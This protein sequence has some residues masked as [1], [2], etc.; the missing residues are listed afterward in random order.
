MSKR[1]IS[2]LVAISFLLTGVIV[3]AQPK[4]IGVVPPAAFKARIDAIGIKLEK[5]ESILNK[6]ENNKLIAVEDSEDFGKT[7]YEYAETMKAAFEEAFKDS[8]DFAKSEGKTGSIE[9]LKSLEATAKAHEL[10][11]RAI[12][13]KARSI[14]AQVKI[15]AIKFDKPLLQKMSPAEREEL[16]RFMAPQGIKEMEKLH[17]DLFKP[18]MKPGASIEPVGLTQLADNVQGFCMSLPEKISNF[19]ITPAE[20]RLAAG[21]ISPCLA[22]KWTECAT[23]IASKGPE[24][25]TAWNTF[26]SCWNGCGKCWKPTTWWCKAK[27]LANFIAKLA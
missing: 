9:S 19:L 4:E 22:K 12:E 3:S 14:E 15:G 25:R 2:L 21:C 17:P 1:L 26:V 24:V 11:L 5:L 20:A 23:C 10:R 16:K 8:E 7:G 18:G 6:V 27:C 13:A